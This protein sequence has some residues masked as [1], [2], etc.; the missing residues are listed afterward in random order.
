MPHLQFKVSAYERV[1]NQLQV[2]VLVLQTLSQKVGEVCPQREP[3]LGEHRSS[4]LPGQTAALRSPSPPH[5]QG[6]HGS[7]LLL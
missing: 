6:G 2:P 3:A 5:S 4:G 7:P 1:G